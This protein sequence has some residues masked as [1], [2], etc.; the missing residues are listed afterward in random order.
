MKRNISFPVTG[1]QRLIEMDEECKLPT[2]YEMCT[3]TE[4]AADDPGDEWK[5]A[6]L[7]HGRV[8][9]LLGKGHSCYRP[10]KTGE[11]NTNLFR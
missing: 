9:L 5:Q 3:A 8:C 11:R 4:V 2:F 6:L 7:T 1:C 10:R